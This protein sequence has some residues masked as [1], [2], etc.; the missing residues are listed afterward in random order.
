MARLSI[1][2]LASRSDVNAS[3][4]R[5]YESVGLLP[6]PERTNG[7]RRYDEGLV[8]R[9]SFIKVAQ[10]TGFTIQEIA[11]LLEGFQSNDSINDQWEQMAKQ[12]RFELIQRQNQIH[13]MIQILDNGLNCKCLTW[14][15]CLEEIQTNGKC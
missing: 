1:G 15:E 11:I 4:L 7:Q 3:T 2:Q 5:Y 13:S 6:V 14:S 8:D 12:K 9:I 10:Q